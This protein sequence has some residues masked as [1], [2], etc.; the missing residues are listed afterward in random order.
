MSHAMNHLIVFARAPQPGHVKTRL[1]AQIGFDFATRLYAAMLRDTLKVAAEAENRN[2]CRVAVAFTPHDA[3]APG[4]YSLSQFWDGEFFAQN[5]SDLGEKMRE[6][7]HS[8]FAQGAK[9]TVIIGSDKP[10]LTTDV[11]RDAF[12]H[13]EESDLVLGPARDGGFY[14]I[15]AR[16]PL[17][18]NLFSNVPW[19]SSQTL[20]FTLDNA[21]QLA[22]KVALLPE[23]AD[24][25]EWDDFSYINLD[26]APMT[27]AQLRYEGF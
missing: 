7:V 20:Q 22:L 9:R 26:A 5:G 1:A 15:G 13:L 6:A 11:I 10:D 19:S 4:T 27:K 21:R 3:L 14:L 23:G 17:P 16:A 24:V 25:D 18:N 2:I 12:A 8:R